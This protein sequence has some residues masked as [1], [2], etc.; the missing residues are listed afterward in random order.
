MGDKEEILVGVQARV[1][2]A[3]V[4]GDNGRHEGALLMLLIAVAATSRK[5]YPRGTPSKNN[6]AKQMGDRE[7]FTTFLRDEIWRLVREHDDF[8]VFRGEKRPIEDFLYEFLRCELVHDGGIPL[9][10]YPVHDGSVLSVIYPDGS[11][12]SFTGL[13][14]ARLNDVVGRAPENSYE[15]VRPQM[16]AVKTRRIH[17]PFNSTRHGSDAP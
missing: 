4:L 12:I 14:L 8:V 5:R 15:A 6:P 16:E 9:D 17:N 7:A 11:G 1:E 10:L 13:L 3:G 2:D